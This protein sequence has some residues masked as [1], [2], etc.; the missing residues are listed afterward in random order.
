MRRHQP[1]RYDQK[2]FEA[3]LNAAAKAPKVTDRYLAS[4]A[5]KRD[6]YLASLA[7]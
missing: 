7:N 3:A 4:L 1:S 6:E 5:A 2:A